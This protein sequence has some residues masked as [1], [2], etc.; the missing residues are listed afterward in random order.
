M[1]FCRN[2]FSVAGAGGAASIDR[3]KTRQLIDARECTPRRA[4]ISASGERRRAMSRHVS[5][6]RTLRVVSGADGV[7]RALEVPRFRLK[8][9]RGPDSKRALELDRSPVMIGSAPGVD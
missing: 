3:H 2:G 1:P 8:V 6:T 5:T 7:A 4:L 9:A